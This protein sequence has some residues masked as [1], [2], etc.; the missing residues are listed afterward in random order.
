M[1]NFL[2]LGLTVVSASA[3]AQIDG[4]KGSE[5]DG[6][7]SVSVAYDAAAPTSNFGA[8]TSTTSGA[9]YDI[10]LRSDD[11]YLYG[12][13]M[14]NGG[15]GTSA[16]S[17]ANLYFDL[18]PSA[19]NGS[20]IGFEITNDRSFNPDTGVYQSLGSDLD[21]A[22]TATGVEFALKWSY[23][24]DPTNISGIAVPAGGKVTLR[25][26]QSFGYSVAG[27]SSYGEDR[28][29]SVFAPQAVPE[30]ASFAALGFGA[31]ALL[32]RRRR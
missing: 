9:A 2:I 13:L 29:G 4:I 12:L 18:N 3:F 25:L 15:G 22:T 6:V 30:P 31:L 14:T 19:G 17:F 27:G 11:T 16:G 32:R 26:S 24:M 20:D 7:G 1:K 28:L 5:W 23:L 21:F 8:P 10:Y